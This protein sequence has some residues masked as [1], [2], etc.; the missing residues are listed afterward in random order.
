[1]NVSPSGSLS[2]SSINLYKTFL[3]NYG[4]IP[5]F[6]SKSILITIYIFLDVLRRLIHLLR[7][8]R[9]HNFHIHKGYYYYAMR[10]PRKKATVIK[11]RDIMSI[12]YQ[13]STDT[14][15]GNSTWTMKNVLSLIRFVSLEQITKIKICHMVASEYTEVIEGR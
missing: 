13:F 2:R 3:P 5:L 12:I 11:Q 4:H 8:E 15:H 7:Q 14:P 6:L 9:Q 10:Y 1:M